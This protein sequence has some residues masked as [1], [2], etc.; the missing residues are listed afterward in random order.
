[1]IVQLIALTLVFMP[2]IIENYSVDGGWVDPDTTKKHQQT[3]S[4][5]N[6]KP[7]KLVF[8]DEFNVP[9]YAAEPPSL[10]LVK[11][12]ATRPEEASFFSV[13]APGVVLSGMKQSEDGGELI[14]RLAEVF[15]KETTVNLS[16][17]A[18][19]SAARRSWSRYRLGALT[20]SYPLPLCNHSQNTAGQSPV[21]LR[22]G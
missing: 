21:A 14:I 18:E 19:I 13:D 5:V 12:H 9:A 1:M 16:T 22:S 17:P 4:Y 8:S 6:G 7:L 2:Y 10:A 15:G 20:P 11:A 3:K